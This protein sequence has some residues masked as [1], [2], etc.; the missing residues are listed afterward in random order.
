M[1]IRN[2]A[3]NAKNVLICVL[4]AAMVLALGACNTGSGTSPTAAATSTAASSGAPASTPAV[5]AGDQ[6]TDAP[7]VEGVSYPLDTN[8]KLT[9]A[10]QTQTQVTSLYT[11][12]GDAPFGKALMEQ[13]GV[14]V[15]FQYLLNKEA[16]SL[17]FASGDYPDIFDYD[18]KANYAGGLEQAINENVIVP[19]NDYIETCAPDYWAV[20][21]SDPIW[22]KANKTSQGDF[23][24][25]TFLLEE[26][27]GYLQVTNGAVIRDDWCRDL[28][29]DLPE[30]PTEVY[31]MLKLFKEEKGATAPFSYH[32]LHANGYFFSWA[33]VPYRDWY[34]IDGKVGFGAYNPNVKE[35]YLYLNKLYSEG[36]IDKNYAT[37]DTD[38]YRSNFMNGVSGML[39]RNLAGGIATFIETMRNDENPEWSCTGGPYLVADELK[40]T[41]ATPMA[42]QLKEGVNSTVLVIS[43]ACEEVETA[44]KFLNYGYT[45]AGDLLYNFGVEGVSYEMVDGKPIYTEE[46]TDNP[47]GLAMQY[48]MAKYC[49]SWSSGPFVQDLGY[50]EQYN[51]RLP[52]QRLAVE[53]WSNTNAKDHVIHYVNVSAANSSEFANIMS[54]VNTYVVE[55]MIKFVTGQIDIETEFDNYLGQLKK[56]GIETAIQYYQESLDEFNAR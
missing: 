46:V 51:F 8:V 54:E 11:G 24:G 9:Y 23:Y 48:A 32:E 22:L 26:A 47:D 34:Q 36:L 4:I 52:E 21:N 14:E 31:E 1:F 45:D 10:L 40:G 25:F 20:I 5:G 2:K 44:V 27:G 18:F 13:T 6:S 41:G 29:I 37:L 39:F 53:N 15:D 43:S 49:R 30:T 19:I 17:I 38:T 55:M 35:V 42:G 33:G 7:V 3:K 16:F 56:L 50:G 28:G 12:L